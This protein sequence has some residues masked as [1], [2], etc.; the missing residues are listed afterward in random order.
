MT[1][2]NPPEPKLTPTERDILV[3]SSKGCYAPEVAQRLG[4]CLGTVNDHLKSIYRKLDVHSKVE[5]AVWAVKAG[6]V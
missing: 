4:M 3:L 6:L 5:A 1:I 2:P